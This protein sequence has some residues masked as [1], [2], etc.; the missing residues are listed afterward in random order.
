MSAKPKIFL[1]SSYNATYVMQDLEILQKHYTVISAL[2][3]DQKRT[4]K[5]HLIMFYRIFSGVRNSDISYIWFADFKGFVTVL[6]SKFFKKKS[7]ILVGGYEVANI[8]DF[9]YGGLISKRTTFFLYF[10]L[11]NSTKIVA[12]SDFSLAEILMCTTPKK[13]IKIPLGISRKNG[14]YLTKSNLVITVGNALTKPYEMYKL[15][16]LET[17]V[18]ASVSF[19]ETRF[20]I[21]GKY[22]QGISEK[23]KKI[24]PKIEFTGF[25]SRDDLSKYFID[26]KV[27]CQLSYRESFGLALLEAM[28]F[29]C[30]PVVTRN[31]ALPEIVGDTGYYTSYENVLET[32]IAIA[33]ALKSEN[34]S[35]VMA[36]SESEF[37]I[38][39]REEKLLDLIS[40]IDGVQ[41]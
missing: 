11:K 24:N 35:E 9:N 21:I 3:N 4:F 26:A 29:G 10:I 38:E 31:G 40:E 39:K 28:S 18:K 34:V 5:N 16:G 15:K 7:F 25:L 13:I 20:I 32:K 1:I 30:I 14:D 23:L 22:E 19:P 27:Y 6:L 8:P 33:K 2:F 36:R 12:L 37:S 17:F 41:H